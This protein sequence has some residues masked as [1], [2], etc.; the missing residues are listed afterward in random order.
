MHLVWLCCT[1][2]SA[3]Y[4]PCSLLIYAVQV[5]PYY[6]WCVL[7]ECRCA[8]RLCCIY[9]NTTRSVSVLYC[10]FK[11]NEKDFGFLG[12]ESKITVQ[13]IILLKVAY[14]KKGLSKYPLYPIS[15]QIF[16]QISCSQSQLRIWI[17]FSTPVNHKVRI[18]IWRKNWSKLIL[19]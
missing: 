18:E 10:S 13:K 17:Q 19:G 1:L 7:S 5:R 12:L 8:L 16:L 4:L 15:L 9:L 14:S 11:W 2:K 6:F 3:L